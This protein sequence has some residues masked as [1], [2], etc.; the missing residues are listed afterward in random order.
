MNARRLKTVLICLCFGTLL[1][2]CSRDPNVR[3]QKYFESGNRYF[4]K[5]KYAEAVVEYSSAI[6]IDPNFAVAHFKL[7]ES[8]L[9]EQRFPEAY[10]ELRRTIELD[11]HN[12]SAAFDLGLLMIAGR[13]YKEVPPLAAGMLEA[14]PQNAKAHLLLS[15][16]NR[17][18]G[19]M[20]V[21]FEE[22]ERAIVLAP[23]QA[24][25][26]VQLATLQSTSDRTQAAEDS[27]KK[28]L[29]TDPKFIPAI[30]GLASLEETEGRLDDA[31]K[32]LLYAIQIDP[33]AVE[34]RKDLA[35]L[36][37]NEHRFGEAEQ[38][39]IRAKRELGQNGTSYRIL[40]EFYNNS[41]D[42]DK[43][44]KEFAAISSAHPDDVQ[45]KEDYIRLLLSNNKPEEASK[46]NDEVLAQHPKDAGA[47]IIRASILNSQSKFSEAA[48]LLEDAVKDVPENA[49]AHYQLGVALS[50]TGNAKRAEQEWFQAA[51]LAPDMIEA[52][53]AL[54]Q[55]ALSTDD[56]TLLRDTANTLIRNNS[57]DP[58]GYIL[59]AAAEAKGK[60]SAAEEQDLVK[61]IQVEPANPT[62]YFAMGNFEQRQ[63]KDD[64]ALRFYEQ[65]L[66]RDA[67]YFPPLTSSVEILMRGKQNAKALDRV[68]AQ[69]TRAPNNDAVY[70]LLGGLQIA[71][72]DL[73]GAEQSLQKAIQLNPSNTDAIVLLSKV[74]M[75][76]GEGDKA[77]AIAYKSISDSPKRVDAYFFAGT[78]EELSG[79]PQK[80]E[81]VYRKAL[82]VDSSYAPAANNLA[83]L[84]LEN[85]EDINVAISLAQL[86]RQKM[87][88]SPGAADTLAWAY[89]QK[90]LY[91]S[92]ADLLTEAVQK[93]PD[94]ATYHYHLGMIYRKQKNDAAAKKQ[95]QRALQINPNSPAAGEIR[96][97]LT[98]MG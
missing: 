46:L 91:D 92:A 83:Y 52:Q 77:L 79:R 55:V 59:R 64:A 94:N 5:A 24:D 50:R 67:N 26:Y 75:A 43:A 84:M 65:A 25:L 28:A 13:S 7:G 37:R 62:S 66:D 8:Y 85:G 17:S 4:E 87:P 47:L 27:L 76:R 44:L 54:G 35:R 88:D 36:Y 63:G 10:R 11:P 70:F 97:T 61:A 58:R 57:S 2:E 73:P 1:T 16:L 81:E 40:G 23:R 74:A 15:E 53:V 51:K 95:L 80:A 72:Q 68:R 39:M 29:E 93:A 90:G 98:E 38:L 32:Q 21:A 49:Y 22:I 45:T 6:Q 48:R 12:A 96:K 82:Q 56:S 41:G 71:N 30:Q 18:E 3:K 60:Q 86:A 78:M 14:D 19:N 31:E 34:L 42:A 20:A 9:K 69:T 33:S 89:Y